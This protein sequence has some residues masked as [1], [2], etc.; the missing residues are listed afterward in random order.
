MA[1][2]NGRFFSEIVR[3]T[4]TSCSFAFP[5]SLFSTNFGFYLRQ[6]IDS[7]N[8][9]NLVGFCHILEMASIHFATHSMALR[10]FH[11]VI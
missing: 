10:G 3:N 9:I 6:I 8:N 1:M 4:L 11:V 5:C 7:F 2:P